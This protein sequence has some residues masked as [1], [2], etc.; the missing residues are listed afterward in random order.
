MQNVPLLELD[1]RELE[2]SLK[3]LD[4]NL[5]VLIHDNASI[6]SSWNEIEKW[7][8]SS[9]LKI[10]ACRFRRNLG[11]QESLTLACRNAT[12]D[13]FIIYQSDR[14]DPLDIILQLAASWSNGNKITVGVAKNRAEKI[15][16]KLGRKVFVWILG[17]S[18]DLAESIWFT[19]FYCL[20]KTIYL[21]IGEFPL[22][23]QFVRGR[24]LE[25]FEI[26]EV[27]YYTRRKRMAGTSK[28][29]FKQ[30]YRLAIDALLLQGTR[31]IRRI[32]LL[33]I[34]ST[35]IL[36]ILSVG[37][38]VAQSLQP[39][40][41]NVLIAVVA[42]VFFTLA[43]ILMTILGFILEFLIRIYRRLHASQ[44]EIFGGNQIEIDLR[45]FK[46]GTIS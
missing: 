20:D 23:H 21:Q 30:R 7:V 41:K 12:G 14:Q 25:L 32:T 15:L 40:S 33:G 26:D 35:C 46:F 19:D 18:S 6:D 2:N 37:Y 44:M 16:E 4:L 3:V 38:L 22:M 28:F 36:F 24:I 1:M 31:I 43:G 10:R 11:Y 39:E 9:D 45:S 17:K 13:A 5:E 42:L 29:R 27:V 8:N 34:L